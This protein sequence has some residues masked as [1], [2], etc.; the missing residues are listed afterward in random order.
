[1]ADVVELGIAVDASKVEGAISSLDRL[2]H[3]AERAAAALEKLG[4]T[5]VTVVRFGEVEEMRIG[6]Q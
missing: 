3:A 6:V 5:P 4:T 1:M 2:A